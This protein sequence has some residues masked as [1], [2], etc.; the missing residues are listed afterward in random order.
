ML[1]I[2]KKYPVPKTPALPCYY[3]HTQDEVA[4]FLFQTKDK[5][6]EEQVWCLE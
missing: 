3:K 4:T 6:I 2:T 1:F 5:T